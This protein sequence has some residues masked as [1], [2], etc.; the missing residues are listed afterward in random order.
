MIIYKRKKFSVI[1][2]FKLVKMGQITFM[3]QVIVFVSYKCYWLKYYS[4]WYVTQI[5]PGNLIVTFPQ[6][7]V[8]ELSCVRAM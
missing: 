1:V 6:E 8:S 7:N 4:S 5:N 3:M 2:R